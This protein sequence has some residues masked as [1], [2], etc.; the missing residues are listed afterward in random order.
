MEKESAKKTTVTSA[1]LA[2]KPYQKAIEEFDRI[3][4]ALTGASPEKKWCYRP[5]S[6]CG[7]E[8]VVP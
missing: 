6:D 4:E 2:P 8:I 5:Q 7:P 1:R 3:K